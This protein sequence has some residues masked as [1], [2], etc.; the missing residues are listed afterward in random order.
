M[1]ISWR[2][3]R[4]LQLGL[5]VPM[6]FA[7]SGC[8]TCAMWNGLDHNCGERAAAVMLSPVTVAVDAAFFPVE[9]VAASCGQAHCGRHYRYRHCCR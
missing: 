5:A 8:I 3:R 4:A 6:L 7:M 1:S 2:F 9:I